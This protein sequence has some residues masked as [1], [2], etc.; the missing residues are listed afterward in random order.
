[1]ER[2]LHLSFLITAFEAIVILGVSFR[3]QNPFRPVMH[4]L[5][6]TVVD[7][8]SHRSPHAVT[9]YAQN[10]SRGGGNR[11]QH[12]L[13]AAFLPSGQINQS[14]VRQGS[15]IRNVRAGYQKAQP[16]DNPSRQTRHG[17]SPI[18]VS[19]RDTARLVRSGTRGNPASSTEVL[20][21]RELRIASDAKLPPAA[22][23]FRRK[24]GSDR[25]HPHS[26]P[27]IAARSLVLARYLDQWRRRV[28]RIGNQLLEHRGSLADFRGHLLLAVSLRANGSIAN[29]HFMRASHNQNLNLLALETLHRAE[30]F[31]PLPTRQRQRTLHFVYEWVFSQNTLRTDTP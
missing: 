26:L 27:S 14:G 22:D 29:I 28:E 2:V 9:V 10:R 8:R 20:D 21:V 25:I 4:P 3:T 23:P 15:G 1:M 16:G 18:I 19:R 13:H 12:L 11:I 24:S 7:T 30:P 5:S 17:Q 6:V 31:P